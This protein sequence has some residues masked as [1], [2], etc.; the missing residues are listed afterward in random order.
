VRNCGDHSYLL[1]IKWVIQ[2]LSKRKPGLHDEWAALYE[3][4]RK[5]KVPSG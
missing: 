5:T 4:L 3:R 1:L 2:G